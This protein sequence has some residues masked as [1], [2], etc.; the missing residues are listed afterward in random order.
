M[1]KFN[2]PVQGIPTVANA[3]ADILGKDMENQIIEIPNENIIENNN[4]SF[5]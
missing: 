3:Y 1:S 2:I 5:L 4:Q